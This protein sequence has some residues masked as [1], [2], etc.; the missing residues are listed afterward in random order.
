MSWL[1][2]YELLGSWPLK[3]KVSPLLNDWVLWKAIN[4]IHSSWNTY[5]CFNLWTKTARRM[6]VTKGMRVNM[7]TITVGMCEHLPEKNM[8]WRINATVSDACPEGILS[9]KK[10]VPKGTGTVSH[11]R[12]PRQLHCSLPNGVIYERTVF[13]LRKLDIFDHDFLLILEAK[14]NA[15]CQST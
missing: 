7:D 12:S 2:N 6:T 10:K 1:Y 4:T 15:M 9:G 5:C 14:A 3:S 13:F 8:Y 11:K